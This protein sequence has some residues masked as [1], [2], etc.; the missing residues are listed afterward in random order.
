MGGLGR[1]VMVSCFYWVFARGSPDGQASVDDMDRDFRR[2]KVRYVP[3]LRQP[4]IIMITPT[5]MPPV[6]PK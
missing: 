5:L 4:R 6:T 2:I 1:A 3:G